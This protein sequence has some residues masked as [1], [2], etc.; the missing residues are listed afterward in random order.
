MSV[1]GAVEFLMEAGASV[2]GRDAQAAMWGTASC[3]W[4]ISVRERPQ[5]IEKTD[6]GLIAFAK[7]CGYK[8]PDSEMKC[9]V[10]ICEEVGR[11]WDAGT[12][13]RAACFAVS[14]E[15]RA[16]IESKEGHSS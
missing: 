10:V 7:K 15:L 2:L 9:P 3:D 5:W 13:P 6:E 8:E 4:L 16:L 11:R 14:N 1:Q 12:G